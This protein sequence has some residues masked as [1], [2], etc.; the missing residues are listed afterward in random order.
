[1]LSVAYQYIKFDLKDGKANHEQ[2]YTLKG[3]HAQMQQ[4]TNFVISFLILVGM[5]SLII[6]YSGR[7]RVGSGGSLEH[8]SKPSIFKYPMKMK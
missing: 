6:F 3:N 1:M 5:I 2:S 4:K 7:S 8:L